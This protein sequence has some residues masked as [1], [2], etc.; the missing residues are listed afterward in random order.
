[1]VRVADGGPS[2]IKGS[3]ES[4]QTIGEAEEEEGVIPALHPAKGV[5]GASVEFSPLVMK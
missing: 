4:L 3:V 2:E 5:M 1:M